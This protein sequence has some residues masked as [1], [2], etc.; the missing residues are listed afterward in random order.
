MRGTQATKRLGVNI[1]PIRD[2]ISYWMKIDDN[3]AGFLLAEKVK[4]LCLRGT[5]A[6]KVLGRLESTALHSTSTISSPP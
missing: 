4:V 3:I 6:R 5:Q 1:L 2:L